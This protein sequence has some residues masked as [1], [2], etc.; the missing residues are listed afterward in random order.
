M[1]TATHV[2]LTPSTAGSFHVPEIKSQSCKLASKLLE[3]NHKNN[4]MYFNEDGFH[5][6]IAHHLLTIFALGATPEEIQKGFDNN[7]YYQKTLRSPTVA[8]T[9]DL[10]DREKFKSLKGKQKNFHDL[11]DFFTQEIEAKGWKETLKEHLFAGDEHASDLLKRMFAGFYHPI[12]HLGLGIEFEQPAIMAEALAQAA[13]HDIWIARFIDPVTEAAKGVNSSKSLVQLMNE[14]KRNEKL[15]TAA[16]WKDGN[17][18]RDGVIARAGKEMI[19]LAA[20]WTVKPDELERKTAE[21]MNAALFFTGAA[22]RAEKQNKIDFY[23]MH[24]ANSA[25]FFPVFAKQDWLSVEDKCWL[26][27]TKGRVDLAMY[28]SRRTPEL[29][30]DEIKNYK[31]KNPRDRW[32]EIFKRV[33]RF[34]DD[35]HA[36]KL[37][38]TIAQGEKVCKPY[39]GEADDVFPLKGELWLKLA[40][41]AIDSVE[42]P[43]D[44]WVRSAGFNE[45]WEKVPDKAKL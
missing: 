6:H 39:E 5:N 11:M 20:Q 37:I 10:S 36:S 25:I 9:Q 35:G 34:E 44:N 42:A 41:M 40:H 31:A 29:L 15:A 4:H 26:L 22:Q 32:E 16:Q 17:K 23:F 28:V 45:A 30:L 38:R 14:A 19:D 8:N 13:T 7:S 3:Y 33:D 2:E 18:V 21:M 24:C 12:I 43:G 1:A 27:E